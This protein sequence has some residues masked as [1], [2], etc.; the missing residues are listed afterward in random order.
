MKRSLV[1]VLVTHSKLPE[2][3]REVKMGV[4][5]RVLFLTENVDGMILLSAY[6]RGIH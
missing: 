2:A 5:L 6:M 1:D 3:I 4:K